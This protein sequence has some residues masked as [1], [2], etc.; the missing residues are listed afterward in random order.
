MRSHD[1]PLIVMADDDDDDCMLAKDA[2]EES[3]APGVFLCVED[4]GELLDFLKGSGKYENEAKKSLPNLILLD[5]NMPR[6]DGRQ[7]LREIKSTP[8]LQ[9]I[10]VVVFTTSSEKKDM[11]F[12]DELGANSFI[13]KPAA[14]GE[15][16]EIMRLLAQKWLKFG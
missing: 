4:G 3:K 1:E 2:F 5:L 6:K 15:W 13:T 7:T 9:S 14:F 10:P 8:E 11:D 16:I 12:C